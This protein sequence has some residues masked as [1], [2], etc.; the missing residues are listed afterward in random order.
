MTTPAL[1]VIPLV[2]ISAGLLISSGNSADWM[3][4]GQT[5]NSPIWGV[6]G[7]LNFALH[8]GGFTE[9]DGGPRGLIR[10]GYPTLPD[11]GYDLIN[12]IAVEPVVAGRKGFSEL[13]K[14]SFD[15]KNGKLFWTGDIAQPAIESPHLDA[16][17]VST[18]APGVEELSVTV[19]V[20][21]F[22]NGAHVRLKLSQRSDAPDELKLTVEAEPDSAPIETCIL[23]ATMG[24]KARTRL[25]FLND[26]PVSSLQLYP[27]YRDV[28]FAD[29]MLFELDRLPRAL[30]GD[31]FV[32]IAND[33]D[34]P[35]TVQPFGRPSFWDYKGTKVTQYWR[36]PKVEIQPGLAA[37]VN[38]RFTYW[39]GKQPIP[40]GIAFENFE[41]REPFQSGQSFIFGIS[42]RN[43]PEI[44]F[45][46]ESR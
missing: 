39:M 23:T 8:P 2:M 16:G 35:S 15:Q 27:D 5:T 3:R 22:D 45:P 13:E 41:L 46:T 31:V 43:V 42:N 19:Y 17:T 6:E 34:T 12:F 9:G 37:V 36:K 18:I 33:E 38:A 11:G 14:S 32:P 1:K 40:G 30:N 44:L 7:G 28:H 24:N 21:K 25:L 20:E 4:A 10:L 29:H 26:G